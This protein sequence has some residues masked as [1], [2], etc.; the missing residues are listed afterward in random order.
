MGILQGLRE[1]NAILLEEGRK[2]PNRNLGPLRALVRTEE[3]LA[4]ALL[5]GAVVGTILWVHEGALLDNSAFV[6]MGFGLG[7]AFSLAAVYG[8]RLLRKALAEEAEKYRL[9]GASPLDG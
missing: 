7:V 9:A 8:R 3:V 6:F 5:V 1:W 2:K 4:V